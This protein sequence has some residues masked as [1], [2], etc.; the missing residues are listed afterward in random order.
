LIPIAVIA[1]P[2][3]TIAALGSRAARTLSVARVLE[4]ARLADH[5]P[6][7][8][9]FVLERLDPASATVLRNRGVWQSSRK[10]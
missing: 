2:G 1:R 5:R 8:W 7:A 6:P 10:A 3:F 9:A 4:P